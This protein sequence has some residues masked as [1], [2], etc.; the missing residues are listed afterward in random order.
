MYLDSLT[1]TLSN[2]R[3]CVRDLGV[4]ANVLGTARRS[5]SWIFVVPL[6]LLLCHVRRT[7]YSRTYTRDERKQGAVRSASYRFPERLVQH[8]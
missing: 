1:E 3:D 4:R 5:A 6:N 2:D 7:G 8:R